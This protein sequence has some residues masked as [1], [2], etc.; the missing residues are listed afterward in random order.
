MDARSARTR[1]RSGWTWPTPDGHHRL[2]LEAA[3]SRIATMASPEFG[4]RLGWTVSAQSISVEETQDA[5]RWLLSIRVRGVLKGTELPFTLRGASPTR[6]PA[7]AGSLR[8]RDQ[9]S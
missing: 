8:D 7:T 5:R 6:R 2:A 4:E 3:T 9:R 1:L